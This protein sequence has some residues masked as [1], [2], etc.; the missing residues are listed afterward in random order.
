Q[1]RP[2][3]LAE[4]FPAP[5]SEEG[6]RY[7]PEVVEAI[8]AARVEVQSAVVGM[9]EHVGREGVFIP[10]PAHAQVAGPGA[11]PRARP[12]LLECPRVDAIDEDIDQDGL[13]DRH[14][15]PWCGVELHGEKNRD[16]GSR[17]RRKGTGYI[18]AC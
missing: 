3:S 1:G 9:G 16:E 17:H 8:R 13:T 11:S 7:R 10:F 18:T 12:V 14:D 4:V 6:Q 5:G 15:W 2:I